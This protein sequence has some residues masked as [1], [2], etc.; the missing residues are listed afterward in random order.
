M[1][2]DPEFEKCAV[3][4]LPNNTKIRVVFVCLVNICRSPLAEGAFRA[5]VDNRGL[6]DR[7]HID[8]AGTS[9]HHDGERPDPRS[10]AVAKKHGLDIRDKIAKVLAADLEHFD[11]VIAMD[12]SNL[13]NIQRLTRGTSRA[14]I[15]LMLDELGQTTHVPDPYYGGHRGFDDVWRMVNDY[16]KNCSNAYWRNANEPCGDLQIASNTCRNTADA[17]RK[18]P[19][20]THRY[21][22]DSWNSVHGYLPWSLRATSEGEVTDSVIDWYVRSQGPT[23]RHRPRGNRRRDIPSGHFLESETIGI[24]RPQALTDAVRTASNGQTRIL[25]QLIDFLRVRRAEAR[26]A[27]LRAFFILTQAHRK[28]LAAYR[29]DAMYLTA[30]ESELRTLFRTADDELLETVLDA[31]ELDALRFG[32]RRSTET[33]LEHIQKLPQRCL[34]CLRISSGAERRFEG[35]SYTMHMRIRWRVFYRGRIH[36]PMATE[37]YRGPFAMSSEVY[38]A[39]RSA[40]S[41][42]FVVGCVPMDEVIEGGSDV[43]DAVTFD[44]PSRRPAWTFSVYRGR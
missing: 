39:V 2:R 25:I 9:G 6:T 5:H 27:I 19:L 30:P 26:L 17:R 15:T 43:S 16:A 8:S 37:R 7:F 21:Q 32:Y 28:R 13:R 4:G 38:Q 22:L 18:P 10:V 41:S 29:S 3:L 34:P 36:A 40:V 14:S 11:Y 31:R 20:S 35:S 12:R 42:D 44:V 1:T 23:W 33:E 24:S